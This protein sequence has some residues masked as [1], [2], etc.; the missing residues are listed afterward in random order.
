M[1]SDGERPAARDARSAVSARPAISPFLSKLSLSLSVLRRLVP[2]LLARLRLRQTC[3]V[4]T[5]GAHSGKFSVSSRVAAT[6]LAT[7]V[8]AHPED[9]ATVCDIRTVKSS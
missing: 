3:Y 4:I 8:R 1:G 7:I 6:L 5:V 9:C 2:L